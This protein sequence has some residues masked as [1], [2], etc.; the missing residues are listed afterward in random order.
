VET[1]MTGEDSNDFVHTLWDELADFDA[2][3]SDEAL[4]HL[5]GGLCT[6]AGAWNIAWVGAVRLDTTFPGDPVK[7]WRPRVVRYLHP[8]VPLDNHAQER[9]PAPFGAAGQSRTGTN[10]G[11]GAGGHRRNYHPQRRRRGYFS[12]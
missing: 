1:K 7:G 10:R 11:T 12:R 3:R 2:A 5:M 6:L 9:L 4:T 8:S